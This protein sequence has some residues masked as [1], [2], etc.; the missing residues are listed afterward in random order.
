MRHRGRSK[1]TRQ[2][3]G[4]YLWLGIGVSSLFLY[5]AMRN[6]HW[7]EF[8]A[9]L[10]KVDPLWLG[11][12]ILCSVGG[13][14]FTTARWQILLP[15]AA[16][17]SFRDAFDMTMI[18]YLGGLALPAR[19]NDLGKAAWTG[20]YTGA[21]GSQVLGSVLLERLLDVMMLLL[22]A[23]CVSLTMTMPDVLRTG[24]VTL[25]C[26]LGLAMSIILYS[27]RHV[28]IQIK[29][30]NL[31]FTLMPAGYAQRLQGIVKG[32]FVGLESLWDGRR[33][34]LAAGW[35]LLG[36]SVGLMGIVCS[37]KAFHMST[38]WFAALLVMLT[39][40]LGAL[41]PSSPSGIGVYHYLVVLA[42]SVWLSDPSMALGYAVGTH[43]LGALLITLLGGISLWRKRLSLFNNDNEHLE[44]T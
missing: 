1:L 42:L 35:S 14:S 16:R 7:E 11:L 12:S 20:R 41:I 13:Y 29:I 19:L 15:L 5:L 32:F 8:L 10:I 33:M 40:N 18:G 2:R 25:T 4:W 9:V 28:E 39:I 36:W 3:S 44:D 30:I 22:L 17:L 24:A 37:L 27:T 21:G 31:L 38:P 43:A 34:A 26:G 23:L 6:I